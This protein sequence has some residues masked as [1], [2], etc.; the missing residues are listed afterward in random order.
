[1]MLPM[2]ASEP[3]TY[4]VEYVDGTYG[5]CIAWDADDA[6]DQLCRADVEMAR[7]PMPSPAPKKATVSLS[8]VSSE[9]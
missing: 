5:E 2:T 7:G 6:L 3:R 8:T 1:M 4:N 9:R